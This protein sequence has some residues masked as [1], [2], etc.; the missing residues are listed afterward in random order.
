MLPFL[1]LPHRR[2][3]AQMMQSIVSGKSAAAAPFWTLIGHTAKTAG[4]NTV[5]TDPFDTSTANALVAVISYYGGAGDAVLSDNI[6]STSN[7][8]LLANTGSANAG[9]NTTR[10]YSVVA[11]PVVG[12]G[13]TFTAA[14][15]G[16]FPT[17]AVAAFKSASGTPFVDAN[18]GLG[19]V[20]GTAISGTTVAFDFGTPPSPTVANDLLLMGLG[21][22]S[23]SGATFSVNAGMIITDQIPPTS[24]VEGIA[25]AYGILSGTTPLNPTWTLS[26][27]T[28]GAATGAFLIGKT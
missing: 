17:I 1:V 12:S 25:L 28:N 22:G 10:I 2:A 19:A 20:K 24:G 13:H 9:S 23:V 3:D 18:G 26:A 21:D 16:T 15:T 5:T 27:A 14:F 4:A 7:T 8:W 6:S 11:S